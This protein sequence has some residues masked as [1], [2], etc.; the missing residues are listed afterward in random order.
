MVEL[1]TFDSWNPFKNVIGAWKNLNFLFSNPPSVSIPATLAAQTAYANN[2][3]T[4]QVS[5][6]ASTGLFPELKTLGTYA[7]LAIGA[8]IVLKVIK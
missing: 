5:G 1:W 2:Q 7:L 4:T 3:Q 8:I 6:Q